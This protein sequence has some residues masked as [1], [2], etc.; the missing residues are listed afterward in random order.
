M[1]VFP[2]KIGLQNI[3]GCN[4]PGHVRTGKKYA[5]NSKECVH[6]QCTMHRIGL[7]NTDESNCEFR[8]KLK[9]EKKDGGLIRPI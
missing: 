6:I 5:G 9:S 8:I 3:G 1:F 2:K 7:K 4:T